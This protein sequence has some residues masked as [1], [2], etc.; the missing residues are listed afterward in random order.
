MTMRARRGMTLMELVIGL[1]I[2]SMMTAAGAGAFESLISHRK[3]IRDAAVSTE[4]AVALRG[5]IRDWLSTGQV[6]I[7]QGGGPRGLSRGAATTAAPAGGMSNSTSSVSAA[8]AAGDEISFT[9]SAANPALLGIVRIRMFIDADNNTPEKGLT[10]EYQPNAQQPIVRKM[11]DSTIDTLNVE[12]LDDRTHRWYHSSEA[13]TITPTVVRITMLPGEHHT[14]P[15]ILSVP[16]I[17]PIANA[18][19]VVAR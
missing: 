2:T 4:R 11:L 18:R 9:T 15:P 1:A 10:I 7:Q 12:F 5:M 14:A 3:V 8:Q 13:A 19:R 17:Y 6:Q 16:M